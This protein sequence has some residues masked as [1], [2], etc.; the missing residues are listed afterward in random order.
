[1]SNAQPPEQ[2]HRAIGTRQ[3][4]CAIV[5]S[6][7]GSGI[8]VL[9]AILGASLGAA[10]IV[11]YLVCG[12]LIFLIGLCMAEV[13]STTT[14]SGGSYAFIEKAFGPFAGFLANNINCW[15]GSVVADAAISN[16]LVDTLAQFFPAFGT[17]PYRVIFLVGLFGGLAWLNI[18]SVKKGVRFI[19][20]ATLGKLI[21]LI[22]LVIVAARI[23]DPGNLRWTIEPTVHNVGAASLLLFYAFLGMDTPLSAGGE[24]R[25]PRRTVPLALF[26]GVGA[27]L[28]LYIAIQVVAQGVLGAEL[29][30]H[31]AAPLGGVAGAVF[32]PAGVVVL[33]MVTAVSMLGTM[34]GN[35]LG[36][37]RML[38]AGARNGTMPRVMA[39]V[40]PRG[41]T[42]HVAILVY[43]CVGCLLAITGEFKQLAIISSASVLL[44]YLG[45]VLA[46]LKLRKGDAAAE[47]N[48][49]RAPGGAVVP[50][51]AAGAIV[52]LLSNLERKEL[53]G[54]VLFLVVLAALYLLSVQVKRRKQRVPIIAE[55][56]VSGTTSP[57]LLHP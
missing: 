21:P 50:L 17:G 9:P 22:V 28:V 19:E 44:I 2:L 35:I 55:G 31:Q 10:A 3:L 37:P 20:L 6:V 34:A 54:M 12:A 26:L 52:W 40:H 18:S 57:E 48:G 11:A 38:Y 36:T 32:G 42:P 43:V 7:V 45:V 41:L 51:L 39:R 30:A 16:A 13:G 23:V 29:G 1:M 24:I 14:G 53:I 27:V 4:S 47:G 33:V 8:F 56:V 46:T 49:F 25:D 15:G 5:N